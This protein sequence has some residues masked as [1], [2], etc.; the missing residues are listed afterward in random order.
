MFWTRMFVEYG[1]K[2]LISKVKDNVI[3]SAYLRKKRE[4][5][6]FP[7]H[8]VGLEVTMSWQNELE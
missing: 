7:F 3:A 2:W 6:V 5:F 8:F 1:I 4:M